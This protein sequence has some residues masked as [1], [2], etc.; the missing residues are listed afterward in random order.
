MD[1]RQLGQTGLSVSALGFGCG[2]VGGILVN[3]DRREMVRVVA[4]AIEHGIN[5]FDTAAIYGN[6][7]SERNLGLVL[8]ELRADVIVGT[9]VRVITNETTTIQQAVLQSVDTSLKHLRREQIDLFQLHN[10]IGLERQPERQWLNNSDVE[11]VIQVFE[12]LRE[13]GKIRF[14]GINGLGDTDAIHKALENTIHTI[15]VC[16][17]LINPSAGI[18]PPAGFPFQDY[19][20]LIDRAAARQIGLIAIRVLA[21]GALSGTADRHP[22][23][24]QTVEPI[25]SGNSF[26]ADVALAHHYQFLIEAG[27]AGSL[28]EAAIRFALSKPEVS[29]ALVG[30]SSMEQ[31][32]QALAAANKGPLSNEALERLQA[33][34]QAT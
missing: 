9:K 32:E 11:Q 7:E 30:I 10:S 3:G 33:F 1:Y 2:A 12:K 26:D 22:H 28:A 20:L 21:G 5:Y 24:A 27:Y 15:Q 18:K 8:E 6:G 4:H 16:F 17:N 19:G 34:W 29:T 14:W 25:A 13:A 31:L 23:A